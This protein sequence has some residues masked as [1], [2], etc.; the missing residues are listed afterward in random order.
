MTPAVSISSLSKS[1]GAT[2]AVRDVSLEIRPAEL[3]GLIGPDGAGK[4]TTMRIITTLLAPDAGTVAVLG[5]ETRTGRPEIRSKIGYMPQRFSLYPDLSVEQNL[6]FFADLFGVPQAELTEKK[7]ELYRF[8]RLDPF[9]TRLAGRLSGGMKQKLAL[10]CALI[11]DPLLLVLDEPTTGVDPVS[12]QELWTILRAMRDRGVTVLVSTPYMDEALLCDRISIMNEGCI[13]ASGTP[14][15]IIS[16]YPYSM[17]SAP[18]DTASGNAFASL[19][20][21]DDEGGQSIRSVHSFGDRVHVATE[22]PLDGAGRAAAERA[23]NLRDGSLVPAETTLED[24]FIHLIETAR[25][26]D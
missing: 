3:F 1:Y 11:H 15:E 21:L 4:T 6:D 7:K 17:Y 8:S 26:D 18:R 5:H 13:L 23:L 12:R 14:A 22:R 19:V 20:T 24:V 10:S 9:A 2:A 25:H 16:S